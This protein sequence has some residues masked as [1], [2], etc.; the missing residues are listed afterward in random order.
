MWIPVPPSAE[1]ALAGRPSSSTSPARPSRSVGRGPAPAQPQRLLQVSRRLPL[2]GRGRGESTTD[3]SWDGQT[4]IYE[5]GQ[6]LA[7]TERFP[8]GPR[9]SVAD[10]DLDLLRQERMRMGT[11]DDNRRTVAARIAGFRTVEF[12][13]RSANRGHRARAQDRPFPVRAR[14]RGPPRP[15]LLRGVQHPG[16]RARAASPGDRPAE[17]RHRRVGGLDST[18]ALIVAAKAMDRLRR[19]R[20][21]ILAFTMPGFATSLKNNAILLMEASR[22][23]SS[24][25]ARPRRRCCGRWDTPSRVAR[26]STT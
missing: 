22:G 13:A 9:R 8:E 5:R 21:D 19:P 24:T 11:F 4:M 15:R 20:T 10:I 12:E 26:R 25:S 2:L 1:A 23:R 6:L 16:V 18:H 7:E 3:L 14:R 17:D